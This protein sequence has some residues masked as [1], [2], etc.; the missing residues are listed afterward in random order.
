V[1]GGIA[2]VVGDA[3]TVAAMATSAQR[4]LPSR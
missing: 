4:A 1:D 2:D 3:E